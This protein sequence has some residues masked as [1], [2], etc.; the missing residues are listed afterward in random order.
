[1]LPKNKNY[2]TYK[3]LILHR[4]PTVNMGKKEPGSVIAASLSVGKAAATMGSISFVG[5]NTQR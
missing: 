2:L 5:M 3:P 4:S 1:M